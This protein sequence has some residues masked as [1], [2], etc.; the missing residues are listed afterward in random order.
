[1]CPE[2]K[3]DSFN[4]EPGREPSGNLVGTCRQTSGNH[5]V[6]TIPLSPLSHLPTIPL[7][8]YPTFPLGNMIRSGEVCRVPR[9][10]GDFSNISLTPKG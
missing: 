2:A 3:A 4:G 10:I 7:S 9:R 5:C 8:H 6:P 1:M